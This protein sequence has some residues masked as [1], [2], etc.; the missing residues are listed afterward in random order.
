MADKWSSGQEILQHVWNSG[1][2]CH[3]QKTEKSNTY[4]TFKLPISE[5]IFVSS[6]V[7]EILRK[8]CLLVGSYIEEDCK[9]FCIFRIVHFLI[10]NILCKK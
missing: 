9:Y 10:N 1:L 4:L 7:N 2:E 3:I 5:R 8:L 6:K